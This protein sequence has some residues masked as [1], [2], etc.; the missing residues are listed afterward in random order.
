MTRIA[1][2]IC[3]LS[4]CVACSDSETTSSTSST[5]SASGGNP[6]TGG[7]GGAGASTGATGG[8]PSTG[9]AGGAGGAGGGAG[10][11]QAFALTSPAFT[12]GMMIP[13][14]HTCV[15]LDI[16]PQLDWTSGPPTTMSYAVVMR[17]IDFT[18]N[19]NQPLGFAH[20]AIW[21]IP[22]SAM[23]LP[24]DVDNDYQPADVA[25]AKQAQ[26][27][28]GMRGFA[29]SCSP[30]SINTY[31]FTVHAV[32]DATLGGLDMSTSIVDAA[33]A[34]EAASVASASLSGEH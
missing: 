29:G 27:F 19:G 15:G 34:I 7:M 13:D 33:A 6:S 24:E 1:L 28:N 22:S 8:T 18:Q 20:W 2:A 17:D 5:Q 14:V 16:S 9:G 32:P 25:G 4:I 21:D 12:E 30:N 11:M 23:G 10:G 31:Q 26:T 3:A